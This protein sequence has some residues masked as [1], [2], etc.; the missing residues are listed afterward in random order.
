MT[1]PV[2]VEPNVLLS[3][4]MAWLSLLA[5]AFLLGLQVAA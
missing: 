3:L 4:V 5:I 1:R 2:I